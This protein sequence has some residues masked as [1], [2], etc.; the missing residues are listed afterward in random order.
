MFFIL[1][2]HIVTIA[3]VVAVSYGVYIAIVE[4]TVRHER[5]VLGIALVTGPFAYIAA[6]AFGI[7]IPTLMVGAVAEG[8]WFSLVSLGLVIPS[9]AGFFLARYVIW[10][11]KED[12]V[13]ATRVMLLISSLVLIMFSDIYVVAAGEAKFDNLRPLLP[14]V[15]FLLTMMLFVVFVYR[16][17]QQKP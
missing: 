8:T 9:L 10:C 14:N 3:G 7:S 16:P 15:T 12:D 6:R 1:I 2:S 17:Q 11:M 5:I 13:I 4:T